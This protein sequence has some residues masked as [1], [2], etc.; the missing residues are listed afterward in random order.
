MPSAVV[1]YR[2]V[3]DRYASSDAATEAL[4]ELA[5]IY[6]N[7]KRYEIAALTFQTLAAREPADRYDAWFAA[8]EL[9]DK[10]VKDKSRAREA[11]SHVPSSS[12]HYAEAQKRS[13]P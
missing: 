11:Y 1:T 9:F 2:D 13:R 8:G 10:R 3:I 4:Y 7:A 5:R 6:A 12:S